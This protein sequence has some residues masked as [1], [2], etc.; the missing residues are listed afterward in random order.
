VSDAEQLKSNQMSFKPLIVTSS[1][2]CVARLKK[3][4]NV[5]K[6]YRIIF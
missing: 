4:I 5:E 3:E 6:Q 2:S 1:L